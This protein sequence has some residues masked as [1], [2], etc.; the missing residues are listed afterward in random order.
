MNLNIKNWFNLKGKDKLGSEE[1][2]F[3]PAVLEVTETPPSPIGRA[4]MYTIIGA[5]V[6]GLFWL[7]FGE[8]DEVAVADG[9]IIP[10]GQVKVIQA[11]D[12]GVVQKIYV[13][14]GQ[15]VKQGDVLV[16]LDQTITAADLARNKKELAYYNL[17]IERLLAEQRGASFSPQNISDVDPKD[18]YYQT[19][20]YQS[21][22]AEYQAKFAAAQS[23]VSQ[24][25]AAIQN[26]ESQIVKYTELLRI[27][28]EQENRV[29]KLSLENAVSE[30]QKLD[31]QSKRLDVERNLGSQ[32]AEAVRLQA[33]LAKSKEQLMNVKAEY[34]RD[35]ATKL[36]EDRKQRAT[37]EEEIKK[38][39]E[40]NRLSRIVAPIDGRVGQL[41]IHTVG[42]VVTAA[43]ALMIIVPEDVTLEVE[44]WVANKDIG[45][46]QAGQK[47]EVK[48]ETFNFQKFGTIDC[49]VTEISPDAVSNEKDKEKDLKYR[50]ALQLDKDYVSMVDRDVMLTPGMSV[51]A[52]IK[53]RQKR[54]IEFFLDPFRKYKSEALRER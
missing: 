54:I 18:V 4:L 44:A 20:L 30:F 25:Q 8:V 41:S 51:T 29:T 24:Q 7:Y 5:V 38:A 35:I 45:F 34:E 31:Y 36:V 50:V 39:N 1:T 53:I 33:A 2:E 47:A 9:K 16:E 42:G 46:I 10:V 12:K 37:Y 27:A 15:L 52:E 28:Q 26:V 32:Q 6:V 40:K 23:E 22:T 19:Q 17:E 43:Q 49:V 48:V 13:K 14:E 11:E 21:R 3:L